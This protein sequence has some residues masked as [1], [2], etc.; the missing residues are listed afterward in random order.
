VVVAW[1]GVLG[2]VGVEDKRRGT[3]SN[4]LIAEGLRKN[5]DEWRKLNENIGLW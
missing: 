4:F 5:T 3:N 2:E 1:A